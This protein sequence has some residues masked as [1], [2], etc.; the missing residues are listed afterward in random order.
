M[1]F[2]RECVNCWK[3][4]DSSNI[5]CHVARLF[6]TGWPVMSEQA[7]M[8][9]ADSVAGRKRVKTKRKRATGRPSISN[10]FRAGMSDPL[11]Q[12]SAIVQTSW[13]SVKWWCWGVRSLMHDGDMEK[14]QLPEVCVH[15][16]CIT[17]NIR[18]TYEFNANLMRS[19]VRSLIA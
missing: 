16:P 7:P 12:E 19:H 9:T 6:M 3:C 5:N 17:S 10:I 4:Q 18:A 13:Y 1:C 14:A 15:L 11:T 2:V 8:S